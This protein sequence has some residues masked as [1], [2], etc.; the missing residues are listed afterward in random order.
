MFEGQL[1]AHVAGVQGGCRLEK[2][3]VGFFLGHGT[4][5]DAARHDQELA[6]L[7]PNVAIPKLHPKTALQ[8]QEK[9]IL[10]AVV[11]PRERPLKLDQFDLL[12][13]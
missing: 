10:L 5:L 4:M 11:M 7:Q 6:F 12:P 8:H 1:V 9:L 2:E 13:V 3:D